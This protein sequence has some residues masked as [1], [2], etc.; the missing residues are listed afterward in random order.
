MIVDANLLLYA[1]DETSP[2]H[3]V[4]RNW[5]EDAL[6]GELRVGL[7]WQT[8]GAF[9]RIATHPRVMS[10]PLSGPGAAEIVRGWLEVPNVWVPPAGVGTARILVGLLGAHG[11]TANLVPDAQLAALAI[12]HGVA[13]ASADAD[14]ARWPQVRWINPVAA[15]GR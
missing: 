11:V 7:P 13:V 15:P 4:A 8:V 3:E 10:A 14:F 1:V 6:N 9:L 5:W 12:E 2:H